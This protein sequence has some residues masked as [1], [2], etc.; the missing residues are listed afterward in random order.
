MLFNP[1]SV[2]NSSF[3]DSFVYCL[4]P[5]QMPWALTQTSVFLVLFKVMGFGAGKLH[6]QR[7]F[8]IQLSGAFSL[9][10]ASLC[11]NKQNPITNNGSVLLEN[12]SLPLL[13]VSLK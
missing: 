5:T 11:G 8:E 1:Y 3:E 7:N 12:A 9:G 10:T 2:D 6:Q 13:F 4:L